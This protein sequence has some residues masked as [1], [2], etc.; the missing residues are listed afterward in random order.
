MLEIF[1][2]YGPLLY[3]CRDN[4]FWYSQ[5]SLHP[6]ILHLSY[7]RMTAHICIEKKYRDTIN[8]L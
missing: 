8:Y 4:N 1:S 6:L 5:L 2:E 3:N 7:M